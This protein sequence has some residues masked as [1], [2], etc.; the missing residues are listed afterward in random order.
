M[1]GAVDGQ[2]LDRLRR[3]GAAVEARID[4]HGLDQ[5]AAFAAL[6]EF[7]EKSVRSGRRTVLVITGKGAASRGGGVLR[8]SVPQWLKASPLAAH[9]LTIVPAHITHGGEG[10]IYVVLRRRR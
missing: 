4:L 3:G 6:M 5:N 9:I 1:P 2:T 10:A 8:R 7:I